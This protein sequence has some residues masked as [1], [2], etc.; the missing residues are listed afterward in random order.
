M[1]LNGLHYGSNAL[2]STSCRSG[3]LL[4][5]WLGDHRF[6]AKNR[7]ILRKNYKNPE[8][9]K[10]FKQRKSKNSVGTACNNSGLPSYESTYFLDCWQTWQISQYL[11]SEKIFS[12]PCSVEDLRLWR[13]KDLKWLEQNF[14]SCRILFK[15]RPF[16]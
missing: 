9:L 15:K 7:D 1:E 13:S 4:I 14:A 12:I 2:F 11:G 6:F 5:L 10:F 3:I 8:H 16:C